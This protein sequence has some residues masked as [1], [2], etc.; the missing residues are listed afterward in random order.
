[1]LEF[2][3]SRLRRAS[4]VVDDNKVAVQYPFPTS[5]Y[6]R[7]VAGIVTIALLVNWNWTLAVDEHASREK[8]VRKKCGGR[9]YHIKS[10]ETDAV[11]KIPQGSDQLFVPEQLRK[12]FQISS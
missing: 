7:L 2:G 10:K 1:M 11:P 8:E 12:C 4:A 5:S 6:M 3:G 9:C